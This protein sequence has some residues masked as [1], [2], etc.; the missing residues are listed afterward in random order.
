[1]GRKRRPQRLDRTRAAE[2]TEK[3]TEGLGSLPTRI[4][5][6]YHSLTFWR[7][8]REMRLLYEHQLAEPIIR[9]TFWRLVAP[10]Q[11]APAEAQFYLQRYLKF[12]EEEL[13]KRLEKQSIA[14][15]YHVYRR[16]GLGAIGEDDSPAT[17]ANT[18]AILDAAIQKYGQFGLCDRLALS[19]AIPIDRIF[20]GEPRDKELEVIKLLIGDHPTLVLTQ[21]TVT[22]LY[23]FYQVERL[24]YE[25]WRTAAQLRITG[26]GAPIEVLDEPPYVVD[27]RSD[28]LDTLVQIYDE[29]SSGRNMIGTFASHSGTVF[30]NAM[31]SKLMLCFI[32]NI[33]GLKMSW[34]AEWL[35]AH[36][37]A[38]DIS[39]PLNYIPCQIH[40]REFFDAHRPLDGAFE[41]Q[42][43]FSLEECLAVIAAIGF[44]PAVIADTFDHFRALRPEARGYDGSFTMRRIEDWISGLLPSLTQAVGFGRDVKTYRIS[45]VLDWL[46]LDEVRRHDMDLWYPGPHCVFLPVE[47]KSIKEDREYFID[48]IWILRRLKDLFYGVH[49]ADNNF[50]GDALEALTRATESPLS[51]RQLFAKDGTSRQVDASFAIGKRLIIAECR[52]WSRSIGFEKGKIDAV[53]QITAKIEKTLRDVDKKA[54][55]L[56][57]NPVGRNYDV[58]RFSEVIPV[59]VVPF[60]EFIPSLFEWYWLR[61]GVPRVLRRSARRDLP[62]IEL[63][64]PAL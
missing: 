62:E 61:P 52:A 25:I 11:Y 14:Y 42:V 41:A 2:P 36:G 27:S 35:K 56:A 64:R 28:D 57:N 3:S 44:L 55:W 34:G 17:I 32:P 15:W 10:R 4:A 45:K 1:V 49:V 21:F 6:E 22:Q 37:R 60:P 51:H 31:S 58:S 47:V 38:I 23:E 54:Q 53:K 59:G 19:S 13:K 12:V 29:R 33:T 24:A 40:L 20:A 18:R 8:H 63:P 43:G 9:R 7:L 26:K 39:G 16:V 48:Y 30:S 5:I 46:T 50:K